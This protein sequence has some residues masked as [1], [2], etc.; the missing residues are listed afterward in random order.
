MEVTMIKRMINMVCDECGRCWIAAM[1]DAS[2]ERLQCPDCGKMVQAE[3][4]NNMDVSLVSIADQIDFIISQNYT[5]TTIPIELFRQWSRKLRSKCT[6][7]Y[8]DDATFDTDCGNSI[9]DEDTNRKW[10][11][12]PYCGR[13]I[14][15]DLEYGL[16]RTLMNR[17]IKVEKNVRNKE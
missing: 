12:C 11:F 7:T 1:Q 16:S 13:E 5:E 4:Q 3:P 9:D 15:T 6:W 14:K 10:E 2:T 8:D 17:R